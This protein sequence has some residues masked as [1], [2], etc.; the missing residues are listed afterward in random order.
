[1]NTKSKSKRIAT[2]QTRSEPML[3]MLIL[4]LFIFFVIACELFLGLYCLG[5]LSLSNTNLTQN[6]TSV[7]IAEHVA[8]NWL[9]LL[10]DNVPKQ[11][12]LKKNS[13]HQK[14]YAE[15]IRNISN[16]QTNKQ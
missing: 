11:Y 5:T 9:V 12:K 8:P 15:K 1:M 14:Q 7:S 16:I 13:L 2:C 4:M 6:K 3:S 10:R